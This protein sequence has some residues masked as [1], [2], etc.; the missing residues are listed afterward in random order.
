[1][2]K[3]DKYNEGF[4]TWMQGGSLA[5]CKYENNSPQYTTWVE[6][7]SDAAHQKDRDVK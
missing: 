4:D 3:D 5:E 2:S 7:Y 6:G 1:M